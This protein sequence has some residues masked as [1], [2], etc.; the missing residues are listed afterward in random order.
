[1]PRALNP[2]PKAGERRWRTNEKVEVQEI[3]RLGGVGKTWPVCRR[4]RRRLLKT[5]EWRRF[6]KGDIGI[7]IANYA[8][9]ANIRGGRHMK[10]D[11]LDSLINLAIPDKKGSTF[12]AGG[13]DFRKILEEVQANQVGEKQKPANS[14]SASKAAEIPDGP[15]RVY[16]LSSAAEPGAS[17]A[18]RPRSIQAA[19]RM[20][21]ALEDYQRGL[22]DSKVSLK[23][24]YPAIESL[25]SKI[26]E[27]GRDSERLPA[28]DPLRRILDE[29]GVLAAV[30]VERFNRGDYVA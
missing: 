16:S 3:N 30:E 20:L 18:N 17:F 9:E 12:K 19:E 6:L 29:I 25:S 5:V 10:I 4:L 2:L 7:E 24:L 13:P 27:M 23:A 28:N 8:I 26:H 21:G 11:K 14:D 15:W 1:M 22:G